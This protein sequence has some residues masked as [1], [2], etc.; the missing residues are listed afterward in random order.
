MVGV[1]PPPQQPAEVP[2]DYD[3][4]R[5]EGDATRQK[6]KSDANQ[7]IAQRAA[8]D[9]ALI[10]EYNEKLDSIDKERKSIAAEQANANK[11]KKDIET[12]IE[13]AEDILGRLRNF[14]PLKAL[15]PRLPFVADLLGYARDISVEEA[16]DLIKKERSELIQELNQIPT[17]HDFAERRK[18]CDQQ[19]WDAQQKLRN[20]QDALKQKRANEQQK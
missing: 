7:A 3:K 16:I 15:P 10:Q 11:K 2:F 12:K 14:N 4:A 5:Q 18:K 8:Q 19:T 1:D 9:N 6:E 20:Q 17:A 13:N